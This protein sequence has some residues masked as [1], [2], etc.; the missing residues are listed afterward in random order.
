MMSRNKKNIAIYSNLPSGGTS[1][2]AL[3]N[4]NYLRTKSNIYNIVM[5]NFNLLTFLV[6]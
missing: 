1:V 2:L 4:Y 6:T 3:S 5:I